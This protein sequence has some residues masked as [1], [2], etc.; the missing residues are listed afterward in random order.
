MSN[1]GKWVATK[2]KMYGDYKVY[3]CSLCG[4]FIPCNMNSTFNFSNY[5]PN[6]GASMEVEHEKV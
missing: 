4:S 2:V 6:C 3:V 5:C 1:K